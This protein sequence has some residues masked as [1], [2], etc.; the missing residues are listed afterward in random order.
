VLSDDQAVAVTLW[1]AHTHVVDAFECTAYLNV[2]SATKRT[3]KTR[4]LE[5]LEPLVARPWFTQR[6]SAAAL[7]RKIDAERPTLL[8][9]E[10]DTA[11]KGE[12]EYAEAQRAL[13]NSGYRRSGRATIC[14]GQGANI[15]YRD[16]STFGAKSIAGIGE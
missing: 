2:K 13:L 9:D 3:G 15:R 1:T 7:V 14:V 10:S 11:F 6:V 8:L 16:F 12:K 5:A 4:L